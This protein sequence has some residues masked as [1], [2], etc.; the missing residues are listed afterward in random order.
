MKA[1]MEHERKMKEME[2]RDRDTGGSG[3]AKLIRIITV[4]VQLL[5]QLV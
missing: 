4:I 5:D 3:D 2:I 1:K